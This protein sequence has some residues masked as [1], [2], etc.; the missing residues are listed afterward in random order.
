MIRCTDEKGA[1]QE[2]KFE[3]QAKSNSCYTAS[4]P[5]KLIGLVTITDKSGKDAQNPVFEFDGCF[6]PRA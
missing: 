2:G 1:A 5:S 6:G 3:L 4:G